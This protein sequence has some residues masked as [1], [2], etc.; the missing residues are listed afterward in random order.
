MTTIMINPRGESPIDLA[1]QIADK[2][3]AVAG[4]L[5]AT[6]E[7]VVRDIIDQPAR[8]LERV[9]L[10]APSELPGIM[11][12]I[13]EVKAT[14][15]GKKISTSELL[16]QALAALGANLDPEGPIPEHGGP[17]AEGPRVGVQERPKAFGSGTTKRVWEMGYR[18]ASIGV[19]LG[20]IQ[21]A[22]T[23]AI[24]CPTTPTL[25]LGGGAVEWAIAEAAGVD[26][27]QKRAAQALGKEK[28]IAYGGARTIDASGE[29][30]KKGI[31]TI[32]LSGVTPSGDHK[33]GMTSDDMVTFTY[34]AC[35]AAH[36]KGVDSLTVPAIGTGFAAAFGF[37]MSMEDSLNGFAR[38]VRK[39]LDEV[40][41]AG[42]TPLTR[43]DYNIYAK[44]SRES[45]QQVAGFMEK[46]RVAEALA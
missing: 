35:K 10:G 11:A 38:G 32:V 18:G 43:I 8:L 2:A 23:Q 19:N 41:G 15:W 26:A 21:E 14:A 24:M 37:G 17:P 22:P 13:A 9:T 5:K 42:G 29:L 36:E 46:A 27:F 3:T 25:Q 16:N 40:G 7:Q 28:Q 30:T 39:F 1:R 6:P 45:A 33:G 34:N 12:M 4:K 31:G 44:P 20:G